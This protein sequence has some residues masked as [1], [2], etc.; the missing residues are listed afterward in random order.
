M[1][2]P[3]YIYIYNIDKLDKLQFIKKNK[4]ITNRV[5]NRQ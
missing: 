1:L 5:R 4:K 3:I 2:K